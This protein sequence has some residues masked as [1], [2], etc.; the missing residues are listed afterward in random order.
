MLLEMRVRQMMKENQ[1]GRAAPLA[2]VCAECRAFQG[3]GLFKQMHLVCLCG[4][5]EQDQLMD[6]VSTSCNTRLHHKMAD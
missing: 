6:E 2:K 1:L 4:T 5:S 3:K